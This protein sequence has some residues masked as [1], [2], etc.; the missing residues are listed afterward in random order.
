MLNRHIIDKLSEYLPLLDKARLKRS[1]IYTHTIET[2]L[3]Y[4]RALEDDELI[5]VC[6]NLDLFIGLNENDIR[7]IKKIKNKIIKAREN[8]LKKLN[9]YGKIV[10][11]ASIIIP[12]IA[13]IYMILIY[14]VFNISLIQIL[15]LYL[16]TFVFLNVLII[17]LVIILLVLRIRY[18]TYVNERH[19]E[20]CGK[21]VMKIMKILDLIF[22][23]MKLSLNIS[24]SI[25]FTYLLF[26]V[27]LT[28]TSEVSSQLY[29]YIFPQIDYYTDILDEFKPYHPGLT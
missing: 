17:L 6:D 15:F 13:S 16:Y 3:A 25:Y 5:Y 1:G 8:D 11:R 2:E 10:S 7:K 12:I 23:E 27:I 18:Y 19:N 14:G 22:K 21:A 20:P 29:T 9:E 4:V 28:F 26:S 24:A